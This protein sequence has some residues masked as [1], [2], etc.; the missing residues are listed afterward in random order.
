[1]AS[2]KISGLEEITE[3]ED[4]DVLP[5]V[6]TSE[7]KTRKIKNYNLLKNKLDK[8]NVKTTKT[9]SD[10]DV[11][12]CTYVNNLINIIY[13]IGSIYMSINS[14]NPSTLFGGTWERINGYYLYAGTGGNTAGSNTSG[15]PSKN[16]SGSTTLTVDQIP[17]HTH[18]LTKSAISIGINE[19]NG[20]ASGGAW[21]DVHVGVSKSM[22][23]V[24]GNQGHTHTLSNH[25]HNVTPLRYEVYTWKRTK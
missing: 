5:I 17:S 8:L 10:K 7:N 25:T 1:M 19:V 9:T 13:P 23:S 11:Y 6:D 4:D 15:T 3:V 21:S 14:T 2:I 22:S 12:S 20:L 24:G 18:N 16:T